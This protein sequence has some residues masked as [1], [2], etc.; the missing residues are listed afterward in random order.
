MAAEPWVQHVEYDPSSAAGTCASGATAAT[1]RRSTS[2]CTSAP[3]ATRCTS[4][5]TRPTN[6]LELYRF[7]LRRNHP[8]Y[9]AR[10]SIGPDGDLYLVGR[11]ALEHLNDDELDRIIG[12]L[13]E[14][15]SAG[16]SPSCRD[17]LRPA[18][19][20]RQSADMSEDL[21]H[22]C[23]EIGVYGGP[24]S[25]EVRGPRCGTRRPRSGKCEAGRRFLGPGRVHRYPPIRDASSRCSVAVG[26]AR[27]SCPGCSTPAGT[28]TP[29]AVAEVDAER[30]RLVEERF[31]AS[32]SCRARRGRWPRVTS[33]WWR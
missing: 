8:M 2:T 21:H 24:R 17:R 11:V 18:S 19:K 12:V 31:R 1:P 10:F 22:A 4:C 5:P 15:R 9:G 3:S 33:W 27:R 28:P 20:L 26:W 29:L 32:A 7:L 14:A 6:H 25:D 16:S 13:Y 23:A 30:R